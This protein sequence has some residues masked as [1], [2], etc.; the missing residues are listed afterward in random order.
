MR[1][2]PNDVKKRKDVDP[3]AGEEAK[4]PGLEG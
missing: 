1:T 4:D 3:P 2:N